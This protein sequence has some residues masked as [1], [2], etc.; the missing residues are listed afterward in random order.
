MTADS[1]LLFY[2]CANPKILISQI[3]KP[4]GG[5]ISQYPRAITWSKSNPS[6]DQLVLI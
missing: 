1:P 5:A 6:S 3:L 4:E 2:D